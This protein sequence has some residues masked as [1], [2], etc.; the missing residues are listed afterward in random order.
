MS[1]PVRWGIWFPGD[2]LSD[3]TWRY[4]G[5]VSKPVLF[6]TEEEALVEVARLAALHPWRYEARP[7]P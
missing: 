7:Y 2:C 4:D 6:D 1:A 5:D 3:P